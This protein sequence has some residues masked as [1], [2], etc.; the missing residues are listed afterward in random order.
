[1]ILNTDEIEKLVFL[2]QCNCFYDFT[3]VVFASVILRK[4]ELKKSSGDS[5]TYEG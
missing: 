2:Y 5:N 3:L 4:K 1:M